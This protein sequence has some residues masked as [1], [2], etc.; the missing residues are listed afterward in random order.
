[1]ARARFSIGIDLGTTNSALAYI[2]L[3]A[4]KGKSSHAGPPPIRH[5]QIPQLVAVGA[6]ADHRRQSP[7]RPAAMGEHMFLG[8][9]HLGERPS[10]PLV[11]DEHRVVAEAVGASR[12]GGDGALDDPLGPD[13]GPV[14][15]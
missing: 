3:R 4:G 8:R 15:E 5:F 14:G 12:F 6:V 2:D 1:M 7:E 10:V 11:R 9:P 13:L